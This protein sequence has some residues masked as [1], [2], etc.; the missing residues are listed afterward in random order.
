[1]LFVFPINMRNYPSVKKCYFLL[2]TH[3]KMTFLASLEKMMLILE[4]NGMGVLDGHSRKSLNYSL[5]FYGYHF[6]F[7]HI[8]LSNEKTRKLNI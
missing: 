7:F 8:R 6:R 5:Y 1:M 4:K 2:K 3:L